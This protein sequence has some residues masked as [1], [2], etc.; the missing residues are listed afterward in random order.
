MDSQHRKKGRECDDSRQD[1]VGPKI[2]FW[3]HKVC[4]LVMASM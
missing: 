1:T 2:V 3:K 4:I